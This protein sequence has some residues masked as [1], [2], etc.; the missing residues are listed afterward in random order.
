[1]SDDHYD[2]IVIGSGAGGGTLA[3]RLAPAG[4]RVLLLERGGYLP[5]ERDNW[6]LRRGLRP[7]QVPAPRVLVRPARQRVPAGGQLLRRR[8]HE[9][10]RR[11]A[12]PAAARG[13][14][15]AAS[16]TTGS[17]RP[18]RSTTRTSSRTTPRPS[19]STGSTDGTART[20]PRVRTA[21]TTPTRP[22]ST[23]RGSSSCPTTWRS[24]ACI[25]ST[26]RSGST[27][28]R[29]PT[30][31]A[32]RGSRCIRCDRV[33]GFPCLVQAKSDSQVICVDPAVAS[34]GVELL[35]GAYV[36][37]L[38]TD[39]G[40][41]SVTDVVVRLR[42]GAGAGHVQRGHRRRRVR[43][44]ELRRAAAAL[45]QRPS[46]GR[47]GERL[48]RRRPQ[49]P[50]A[51]QP[52]HDGRLQGAEPD[53]V[54]ED[55]GVARLVLRRRGLGLPARRHPDAGQVGQPSRSGRTRPGG[56][57]RSRRACRSRCSPTTPSTSGSAA[58]TCRCPPTGSRCARTAA[59]SSRWTRST[60]PRA[61]M[62]LRHRLQGMLGALGMQEHL[63][64]HSIYMHK[65]M[66]IGATA[67]QA[68]TVRFG[69]IPATSALDPDCARRTSWTTSTWWT[70]ASSRASAP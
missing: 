66:P 23:R 44:G 9:V 13:L 3:H 22:S 64:D 25:P 16:T 63:L 70:P 29:T 62:R 5:R 40:G 60:T 35:T 2:V 42:R 18:G 7:G 46:P 27:S 45:R 12:V 41:R 33:D 65:T 10:L 47:S 21:P 48:G 19:T 15:R 54:P 37:R 57:A 17:R 4:K 43:R 59:S 36:E 39:A 30:V 50:A 68:G 38:E 49:L 61:S 6:E 55:A 51:Q 53:P 67:H 56:P 52:R 11:G 14:R 34:G 58:R 24:R 26:S 32:T 8:Q 28:T 69:S 1:M 31:C 20:R